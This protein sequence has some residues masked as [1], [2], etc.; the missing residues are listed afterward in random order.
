MWDEHQAFLAINGKYYKDNG[1]PNIVGIDGIPAEKNCDEVPFG[2]AFPK[3][4]KEGDYFVRIDFNNPVLYKRVYE[5]TKNL[6]ANIYYG[7]DIRINDAVVE[8]L[9]NDSYADG[10][11]KDVD[12]KLLGSIVK[13]R[14]YIDGQYIG[15]VT[16]TGKIVSNSGLIIGEIKSKDVI[17]KKKWVAIEIDRREKWHGSPARARFAINNTDK[18]MNEE[19]DIEE[20]RQNM[21]TVANRRV[22]KEHDRPRPWNDDLQKEIYEETGKEYRII[23][24]IKMDEDTH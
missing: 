19:G 15:Y 3:D 24:Q 1:D 20:S 13:E 9:K 4:A 18:F 5:K 16:E 11:I 17:H 10:S 2:D 23:D 7:D 12:G 22:K 21:K 6:T 14:V 8:L